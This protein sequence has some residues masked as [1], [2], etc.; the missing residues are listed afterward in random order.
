MNKPIALC[1]LAAFLA[2][3]CSNNKGNY[4]ASGIFEATEVIVSAQ[5]NGQIMALNVEEGQQLSAA[6]LVGYVDTIQLYLKKKQLEASLTTVSSKYRDVNRQV[7]SIE[8]QIRKQKTEQE[9]FSNLVKANAANQKQLD[10]V[11]AQLLVLEKQLAAQKE[12]LAGNNAGVSSETSAIEV[13]IEQISDQIDKSL[14][15]SPI[16]GTVL[17]KY[18]EAGEVTSAG[19]ALFKVANLDNMYLRAYITSDQLTQMQLGQQVKVYADFGANDMKEYSGTITWISGKAEF[20]PKTIQTRN[21]RANQVYAVKIAVRN[22]GYLKH[23]MYGE[24]KLQ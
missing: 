21:E 2:I 11:M 8:E 17:S 6:Q 7:A 12:V 16:E 1:C 10:D 22:D 4:D 23:G 3:S 15:A 20:T 5:G 24:M 9:R 19:R 13:Q 14:I 18:A